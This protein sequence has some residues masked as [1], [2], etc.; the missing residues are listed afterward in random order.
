MASSRA[1][2]RTFAFLVILALAA[3]AVAIQ[4]S[5]SGQALKLGG[6]G[7]AA[8]QKDAAQS[9]AKDLAGNQG[10]PDPSIA[11]LAEEQAINRAIPL[12]QIA[13]SSTQAASQSFDN[14]NQET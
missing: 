14:L 2:F 12:D 1:R 5:F 13:L 9:S 11:T 6:S 10:E 3:A 4:L 7:I 8:L